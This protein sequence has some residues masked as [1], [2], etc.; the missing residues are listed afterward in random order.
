[1][2]WLLLLLFAEFGLMLRLEFCVAELLPLPKIEPEKRF[3]SKFVE[4]FDSKE[5][6]VLFI[7]VSLHLSLKF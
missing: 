1:M 3:I 6:K 2:I 7:K 4:V 5:I